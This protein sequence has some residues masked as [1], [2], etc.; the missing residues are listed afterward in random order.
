MIIIQKKEYIDFI[1]FFMKEMYK[2]K[3]KKTRF[4]MVMGGKKIIKLL[5]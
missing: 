1:K 4:M 5:I 2:I 3:N